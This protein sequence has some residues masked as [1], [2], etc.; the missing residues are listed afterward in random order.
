MTVSNP[1]VNKGI[2]TDKEGQGFPGCRIDD[3]H[4]TVMP[5]VQKYL[6]KIQ[7]KAAVCFTTEAGKISK[8]WEDKGD[9]KP[10]GE[11]KE[12]CTSSKTPADAGIKTIEGQIVFLNK[13]AHKITLKARDGQQ[14]TF[15]WTPT[16]DAEF[17]KLNQ[18]WFCKVT[19]EHEK[20]VDIWRATDQGF[21]KRPDD[22][23]FAK[24]GKGGGGYSQPRNE[25]AII[26]QVCYKEACETVRHL[27]SLPIE[28]EAR[29]EQEEFDRYMD[30]AL[31]RALKDAKALIEAAG[32]Q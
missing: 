10:A 8:I 11:S 26:Y 23:P 29:D 3:V 5:H 21:F 13:P 4:F 32:A 2:L 19:G 25:K 27:M 28:Q 7:K 12:N 17:S 16:L 20:D 1:P 24:G 6:D 9:Q 22:W 30:M 14:H 15:L 31:T 18:W